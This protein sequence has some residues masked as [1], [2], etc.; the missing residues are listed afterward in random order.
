[1]KVLTILGARPQFIKAAI[2]SKALE[3]IGID[4]MILHTGQHFDANMS[5]IFFDQLGMKQPDYNLGI[6]GGTHGYQTGKMIE[7]IEKIVLEE[8]PDC[9]LLYGDTN[10]TL[11]GTIAASK[12]KTKIA[13]VEAGLRSYSR[14]MPE[15]INRVLTDRIADILFT[16]TDLAT[17]NLLAEG[18]IPEKILQ[19]GDVMYDAALF[20]GEVAIKKSEIIKLENLSTEKFILATVHR[21]E[22]TDNKEKLHLIFNH[23]E[24]LATSI[25][26]VMPLHPRTNNALKAIGFD[27]EKSK[28]KF[29]SPVGYLDM[30]MLERTAKLIITDSGGVQKEAYFNGTRC[31]VIREETEWVELI[32]IGFNKLL[33][34]LSDL[35]RMAI[36]MLN[37]EIELKSTEIYGSGDASHKIADSLRNLTLD[38]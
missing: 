24:I 34:D 26:V 27:F 29:I 33:P 17:N 16:P 21:A 6:S 5:T 11:A 31:L 1:M 25:S 19:V 22:N 7:A 18:V 20:F 3:K 13:H 37:E 30:L 38:K 12:I 32:E 14:Y 9:I 2:V 4:E 35:S 23:L 28:I 15:E 8:A 36:S 10:S